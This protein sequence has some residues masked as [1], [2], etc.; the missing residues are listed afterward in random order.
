VLPRIRKADLGLAKSQ[1]LP[2]ANIH[3]P[4]VVVGELKLPNNM[5]F[6]S[7]QPIDL[8]YDAARRGEVAIIRQLLQDPQLD[9]N[10]QNGKGHSALILATYDNHLDA[11]RLLIER[12]ADLNLQDASGN[13]AL[14][15]VAFKGYADIARLLIEAGADLNSTNGNGGTALMFATLFGRNELVKI[16]LEA[17]A[18]A[19]LKDVRGL[20]ALHLAGQQGNE[21]AWKLLGG[22]EDE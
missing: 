12:G 9:I 8:L 3:G 1:S 22:S 20:T 17:G 6:T 13:T 21:E 5:A 11:A 15:G 10:A 16:L 18:D 7:S 19:T 4:Q 14:M 2:S